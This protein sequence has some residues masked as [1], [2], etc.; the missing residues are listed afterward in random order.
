MSSAKLVSRCVGVSEVSIGHRAM[1]LELSTQYLWDPH[2]QTAM[3]S[4][5]HGDHLYRSLCD[6]LKVFSPPFLFLEV[7][8]PVGG[9]SDA[10]EPLGV[11]P[12]P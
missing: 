8:V 7:R 4:S 5:C 12:H 10:L 3:I 1:S 11:T 9:Q 2:P 6:A